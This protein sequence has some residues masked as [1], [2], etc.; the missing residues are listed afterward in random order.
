MKTDYRMPR[1]ETVEVPR[2]HVVRLTFDDGLVRELEFLTGSNQGTVFAALDDPEY[3]A[4]V[5]VDPESRTVVWP[6]GVDLDPAV[7]HGDFEPASTWHF[8]DVGEGGPAGSGANS[9]R[10][11]TPERQIPSEITES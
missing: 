3:F 1:V 9:R 6:N 8:R 5:R 10:V 7:L 4:R 2:A 11:S